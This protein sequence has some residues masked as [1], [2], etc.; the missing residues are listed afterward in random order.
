MRNGFLGL[1]S[2]AGLLALS[3]C[4]TPDGTMSPYQARESI[5]STTVLVP[6]NQSEIYVDV[7][8][9]QVSRAT[10]GGLLP[11][12]ID[13]TVD[14]VKASNAAKDLKPLRDSVV[15]YDFDRVLV[16]EFQKSLSAKPWLHLQNVKALK[17]T[18]TSSVK[19]A[20]DK[21]GEDAVLVATTNYHLANDGG[22]LWIEVHASL[23]LKP[24]IAT[25]IM[26]TNS[27]TSALW[28]KTLW[29]SYSLPGASKL[30]ADN[31]HTWA[32]DNG[33]RLRRSLNAG[34][35]KAA[36]LLARGVEVET[37][38]PGITTTTDGSLEIKADGS[39]T[40]RGVG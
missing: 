29:V 2:L 16:G 19:Q 21:A 26:P 1:V 22:S 10:G 4:A 35:V 15:D 28:N 25:K 36:E 31:I 9:S 5:S 18:N 40:F 37:Q 34:A 39:E 12:L 32:A 6:I 20:R 27:P 33:T 23:Y 38:T 8:A 30:R 11:A 24:A 3:A 14:S 13:A 17:D 7:P